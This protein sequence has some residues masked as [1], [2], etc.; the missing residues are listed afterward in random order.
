MVKKKTDK[1]KQEI[2]VGSFFEKGFEAKEFKNVGDLTLTGRI[3]VY[4]ILPI[5]LKYM[6]HDIFTG[7]YGETY[8]YSFQDKDG[9]EL[10]L[11]CKG[12]TFKKAIEEYVNVGD[13]IRLFKTDKN[14]W[15]FDLTT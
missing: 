6:D 9:E 3:P 13:K 11:L 8:R 10:R 14:Y 12:E 7:K 5:V 15:Q 2:D 1:K 4:I